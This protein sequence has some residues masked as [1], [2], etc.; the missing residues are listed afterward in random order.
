MNAM[1]KD[2]NDKIIHNLRKLKNKAEVLIGNNKVKEAIEIMESARNNHPDNMIPYISLAEIYTKIGKHE[3][4]LENIEKAMSVAPKDA[5]AEIYRLKGNL[6]IEQWQLEKALETLRTALD[7]TTI[8]K[9]RGY[10]Y[11]NIGRV[12]MRQGNIEKAVENIMLAS[13]LLPEDSVILEML[14]DLA[15]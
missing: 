9:D 4:A 2:S 10:A 15:E 3:E 6:Y 1:K 7:K 12:Y 13:K 14:R 8:D 5:L 11:F